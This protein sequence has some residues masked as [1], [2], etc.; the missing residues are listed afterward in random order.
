MSTTLPRPSSSSSW[1]ACAGRLVSRCALTLVSG[2][3]LATGN[4][5]AQ[6]TPLDAEAK[7]KVVERIALMLQ[8]RYVDPETAV[9]CTDG[10]R[11]RLASGGFDAATE[12]GAFSANLTAALRDAS[13]DAHLLVR[14]RAAATGSAYTPSSLPLRERARPLARDQQR[15]FGFERVER[16]AGNVGYLDLRSFARPGFSQGAAI[17]AMGLLAGAD[18]VI[19]DLRNNEGGSPGMVQFLSSY[20]FAEPTHLNTLH[21]REG[22]RREEYWTFPD[23]PGPRL[24]DVPVFVLTSAKTF[25]AAEEFSY[26][27][28]TQKRGTLVGETTRG[29]ANPGGLFAIDATF[30]MVIPTGRA[31]NPITGTNWEGTGVVPHVQVSAELALEKALVLARAS[32]EARRAAREAQWDNLE[33]AYGEALR[34]AGSGQTEAAERAL[35]QGL[36]EGLRVALLAERE[37][38]ELGYDLL[39]DGQANLAV[40]AF[41]LNAATFPDSANVHDSLGEAQRAIGAIAA[42]IK[43]YERALELDPIGPNADAAR[44]ILAELRPIAR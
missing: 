40:A 4:A 29:G 36:S 18:A 38:N 44:A 14:V 26:N 33:A 2:T 10:L 37:V 22:D 31:I 24:I 11:A 35:L 32:A 6:S 34:L 5:R 23:V 17:S 16:L 1:T 41:G 39:R 25:S 28:A 9:K 43:S 42:A 15:N 30:E 7:G 8:E 21:F 19:F 3:L 27:L 20:L 13:R 12:P